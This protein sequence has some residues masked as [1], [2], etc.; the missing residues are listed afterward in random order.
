MINDPDY[1]EYSIGDYE[2]YINITL[3]H[4]VETSLEDGTRI[5]ES[6]FYP[7]HDC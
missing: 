2:K 4:R 6:K 1:K 7:V 5:R 3:E